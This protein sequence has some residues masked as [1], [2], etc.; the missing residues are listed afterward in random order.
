MLDKFQYFIENYAVPDK[1]FFLSLIRESNEKD[2]FI[3]ISI[4]T[5]F[6]RGGSSVKSLVESIELYDLFVDQFNVK[7]GGR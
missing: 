5:E 1:N 3:A 4:Y 6:V 7:N 2:A